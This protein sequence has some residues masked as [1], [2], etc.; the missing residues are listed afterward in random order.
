[1]LLPES[2]KTYH[3]NFSE[4]ATKL[5]NIAIFQDYERILHDLEKQ[6]FTNAFKNKKEKIS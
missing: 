1:M 2:S 3:V 5:L 6:H 4:V